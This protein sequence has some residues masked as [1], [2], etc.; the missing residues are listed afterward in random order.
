M[1]IRAI[2]F[3]LD[4]T[5]LRDDLTVSDHTVAVLKECA[6]RGLYIIP[7]SGRTLGSM[8]RTVERID[9]A[10]AIVSCNGSEVWTPGR[11]LLKQ[12]LLP[13]DVAKEIGRYATERNIYCQTYDTDRFYYNFENN[14]AISYAESSSL[15]GT[16]VG[17]LERYI[18]QPVTKMLAVDEP[19]NIPAMLEAAAAVF[20]DRVSV[21]CSK[22]EFIEF[23]PL[24]ATKG[25]ALRW[26]AEHFCFQM[27]ELLA[28]GDS[29]N[30][31]TM[32]SA[33][34]VGVCIG[35]GRED[36]KALGFPVCK[37]N[38]EDGVADYLERHIL[39]A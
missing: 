31:V 8:W 39:H 27:S 38:N 30:D 15:P 23:N 6:A 32:L 24:A 20:S 36:V 29:L 13:V 11:E 1:P 22:P 33:A 34:G 10:T 28:F 19:E 5:L 37:T 17:D 18:T 25:N 9:C 14:Y 4:D 7:A 2:A 21:T 3:D 12:E 16:Y 26:C 35:N